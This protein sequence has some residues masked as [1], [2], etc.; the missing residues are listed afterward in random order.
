MWVC[1]SSLC[2][3]SSK[4]VRDTEIELP[5]LLCLQANTQ[6]RITI[7][8]SNMQDMFAH[9]YRQPN[10]YRLH[11]FRFRFVFFFF[12]ACFISFST[13][14]FNL[15]VFFHYFFAAFVCVV[16]Q[17]FYVH[18][19]P[20]IPFVL[21]VFSGFFYG[22]KCGVVVVLYIHTLIFISASF[23]RVKIVC[24]IMPAF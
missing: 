13:D 7:R 9:I 16:C 2:F 23:S 20:H 24:V 5:F 21:A 4:W 15:N 1:P 22:R 11:S 3:S 8:V 17:L 14:F 12:F 18:F 19:L 10:T 6:A